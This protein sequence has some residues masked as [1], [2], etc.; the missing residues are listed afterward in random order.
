MFVASHYF[1]FIAAFYTG[2]RR[3]WSHSPAKLVSA[4]E[5]R[6]PPALELAGFWEPAEWLSSRLVKAGVQTGTGVEETGGLLL[7]LETKKQGSPW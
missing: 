7:F 2:R 1:S 5:S 3:C 6:G 4:F